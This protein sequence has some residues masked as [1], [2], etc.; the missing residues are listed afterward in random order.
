MPV[1]GAPALPAGLKAKKKYKTKNKTKRI[2]WAELP[3]TKVKGT[4][5]LETNEEELEED[6]PFEDLEQMFSAKPP[7]VRRPGERALVSRGPWTHADAPPCVCFLCQTTGSNEGAAG[8]GE[9]EEGGGQR[10]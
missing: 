9:E 3:A 2:N 1:F 4:F 10:H 6:M 7:K 8:H 5:W